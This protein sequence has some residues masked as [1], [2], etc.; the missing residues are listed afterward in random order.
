[1]R[2][3]ACGKELPGDDFSGFQTLGDCHPVCPECYRSRT[4]VSAAGRRTL[5]RRLYAAGRSISR[6]QCCGAESPPEIHF[7]KPLAAGGAADSR[8][9]IVLCS[10]CH[11]KA[12]QPGAKVRSLTVKSEGSP[13]AAG[14]KNG[15]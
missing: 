15:E 7:I 10:E 3:V 13:S 1:M 2:C 11:R 4:R 12:H 6:C 9:L 14:G 5:L 8:N